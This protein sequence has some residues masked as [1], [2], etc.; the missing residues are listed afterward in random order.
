MVEGEPGTWVQVQP[1]VTLS[2]DT[3]IEAEF[4]GR[5]DKYLITGPDLNWVLYYWDNGAGEWKVAMT[6]PAIP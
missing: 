5:P 4:A 6:P 2:D 1:A 3:E